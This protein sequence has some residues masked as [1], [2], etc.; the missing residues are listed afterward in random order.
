MNLEDSE[1]NVSNKDWI[2]K[3]IK[4][5]KQIQKNSKLNNIMQT[6]VENNEYY[7]PTTPQLFV[8]NDDDDESL[9]QDN[10]NNNN[11]N[12][13]EFDLNNND[14]AYSSLC[15]DNV[16]L[17][18]NDNNKLDQ[19]QELNK[20]ENS[21]GFK[22]VN[23]NHNP[24]LYQRSNSVPIR[25]FDSMFNSNGKIS[26]IDN[27]NNDLNNIDLNYSSL[28]F[29]SIDHQSANMF[30]N[31]HHHPLSNNYETNNLYSNN[32]NLK[33]V[34]SNHNPDMQYQRSTSV[35]LNTKTN[36]DYNNILE[37]NT[38]FNEPIIS[39]NSTINKVEEKQ[40]ILETPLNENNDS[41]M[42]L[43][44]FTTATNSPIKSAII[45][46]SNKSRVKQTNSL[47]LI[48][49]NCLEMSEISNDGLDLVSYFI[50]LQLFFSK[51]NLY[52]KK[53]ETITQRLLSNGLYMYD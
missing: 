34:N 6:L 21:L 25:N 24:D 3:K 50:I 18:S 12:L 51:I 19:Q 16:D 41:V 52:F 42:L 35:P 9:R 5:S 31:H 15:F 26:S 13:N 53:K 4:N 39:S 46:K 8:T 10:T 17:T 7:S 49:Q 47:S 30:E 36:S 14:L 27:A 28:Y 2:F 40:E 43:S 20:T 45:K 23:L 48:D 22:F 29:E 44:N 37:K 1:N 38:S 11:N 33:F 32:N